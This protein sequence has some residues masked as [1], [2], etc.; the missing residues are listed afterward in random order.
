MNIVFDKKEFADAVGI[1]ARFAERR[2]ATLPVLSAIV[3]VAGN[4]GIKLRATNLETGIDLALRGTIKSP[5]VVALPAHIL[6]DI[7]AS[8]SG[9][10][11]LSF[12]HVGDTVTLS[13]GT[14]KSVAKTI[15][16]EDFPT[17][18]LPESSSTRFTVAGALLRDIINSV[19]SF[20]SSSSV[21]PEL[22]SVLLSASGGKIKAVATDSF[23]LAEKHV[24]L[25]K[26]VQEFTALVPAKNAAEIAST[27]PKEKFNVSF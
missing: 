21:R 7:A 22:A 3:I 25:E 18:S 17:I 15:P 13:S 5:G 20:A 8:F 26:S 23:R 1:T 10:G 16:Y 4:D 11:T 27:V 24:S 2:T 6:K 14:A 12:E 9:T 19:V